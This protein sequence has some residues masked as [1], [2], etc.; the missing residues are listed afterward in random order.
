MSKKYGMNI[1]DNQIDYN[2][3][4]AKYNRR[5]YRFPEEETNYVRYDEKG[6]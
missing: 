2:I 4:Q 1:P 3:E 5:M 6:K